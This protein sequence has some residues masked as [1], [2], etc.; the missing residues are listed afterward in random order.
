MSKVSTLNPSECRTQDILDLSEVRE[1]YLSLE[2]LPRV[3]NCRF[4]YKWLYDRTMGK[5]LLIPFPPGSKGIFYFNDRSSVHPVAG[6]VR[7]RVLP[8]DEVEDWSSVNMADLFARGHDLVDH[9]GLQ[10]WRIALMHILRSGPAPLRDFMRA[11]GYISS[12]AEEEMRRFAS[13][14]A[15]LGSCKAEHIVE[16]VTDPFI[17]DLSQPSPWAA[18]LQK[19]GIRGTQ[20]NIW[21]WTGSHIPPGISRP[22][23]SGEMAV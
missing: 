6:D 23:Y 14:G 15:K 8:V 4:A 13:T 16:R 11:K 10:P 22:L 1:K 21:Q 3:C 18:F 17:L 5:T 20:L 2:G 19:E 12:A 9:S 7:F